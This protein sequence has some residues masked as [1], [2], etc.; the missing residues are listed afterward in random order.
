MT[1][2][3]DAG[4][5]EIAYDH[6]DTPEE[7]HEILRQAREQA[8]IAIGPHGPE[9]L[10]YELVR[11]VLRDPRFVTVRGFGLDLQGI[12]SGP[13]W[14][15]A[16]ANI[17]SL[18]GEQHHRLR[19]LVSKAFSPRS[20]AHLRD[21]V[22]AVITGLVNSVATVGRCDVVTDIAKRYPVPVICALLGAPREDWQL[23]SQWVDNIK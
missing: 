21:V 12:T 19:R 17:L 4:L 15:R 18:D 14:D 2:A 10:G 1:I 7:A 6:T 13:L 22:V 23:F 8:P 5:P 16:V 11:T 3:I 9:V 20:A